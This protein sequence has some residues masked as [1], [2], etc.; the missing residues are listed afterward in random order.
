MKAKGTTSADQSPRSNLPSCSKLA[1]H[2][3]PQIKTVAITDVSNK[4]GSLLL[5]QSQPKSIHSKSGMLCQPPDTQE[6]RS[7]FDFDCIYGTFPGNAPL[8]FF[9]L[10]PSCTTMQHHPNLLPLTR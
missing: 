6:V 1:Y 10:F 5:A 2:N 9:L 8:E 7:L 3:S 4:P